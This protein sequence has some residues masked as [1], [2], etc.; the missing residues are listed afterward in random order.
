MRIDVAPA[1]HRLAVCG[2]DGIALA[3]TRQQL[4][5]NS[6]AQVELVQGG[7][8][9]QNPTGLERVHQ[10]GLEARMNAGLSCR[11]AIIVLRRVQR[12]SKVAGIVGGENS[13]AVRSF[14][15]VAAQCIGHLER[16]RFDLPDRVAVLPLDGRGSAPLA[17]ELA[18]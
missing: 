5:E 11:L 7:L 4:T 2:E 17:E 3:V 13:G 15:L 6:G 18:S 8:R 14:P 1:R 9:L 10:F 12:L 16:E